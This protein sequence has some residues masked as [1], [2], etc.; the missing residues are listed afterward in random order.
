VVE[1]PQVEILDQ[2]VDR[3][4]SYGL[5]EVSGLIPEATGGLVAERGQVLP[6][7]QIVGELLDMTWA[8]TGGERSTSNLL[9]IDSNRNLIEVDSAT[10]LRP[11]AV[12]NR[13]QWANPSIIASYNGNF[14][15]LDSG[16]GRILRYRPTADGYSSPPENYFEG[17]ATLDLSSVIDMAIDG[18]I[19]LLYR[20]GTVQTFL[21]GRQVPF[22]LQPPPDSPISSPEALYVGS[23]AGDSQS[24]FMVDSGGARILEYDKE[25]AYLRQYR[26]V[27]RA[28]LEK[29]RKM[30]DLQVDEIGNTFYILADDALYSTDI[31][32]PS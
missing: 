22:V 18:N 15:V 5:D 7:G 25:G 1:G 23:E 3:I 6:D 10:G 14:Y 26:P 21:D 24:L 30:K 20:D 4:T 2:G 16:Q 17:D 32:E 8:T 12:A 27:D 19:W 9:V 28:D 11:L 31:P 13:E 29:L